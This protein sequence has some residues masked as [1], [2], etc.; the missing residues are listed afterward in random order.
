MAIVRAVESANGEGRRLRLV[1]PANEES[2]GE[3]Q[4]STV[5]EVREAVA[6][7]RRA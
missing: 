7:A 3:L 5:A 1:S 4:V 6:R 2:I